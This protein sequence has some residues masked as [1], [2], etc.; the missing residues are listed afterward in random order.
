M[1]ELYALL[2]YFPEWLTEA[3]LRMIATYATFVAA[4]LTFIRTIRNN[5]KITI[6]AV[7]DKTGESIEVA[8]L[9]RFQVTRGEVLGI[10]RLQAGGQNL[11]TSCFKW[12]DKLPGKARFH[13]P[14]E[15]YELLTGNDKKPHNA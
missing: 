14:P 1:E 8:K 4:G 12:N 13:F 2:G 7:N 5:Q 10:M 9:P 15:T 6:I 11:D 3:N